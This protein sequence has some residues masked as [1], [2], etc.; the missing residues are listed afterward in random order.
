[1]LF[2]SHKGK[3]NDLSSLAHRSVSSATIGSKH[4]P[5]QPLRRRLEAL[6]C[7]STV[8]AHNRRW[9]NGA[10]RA[11]GAIQARGRSPIATISRL[12][13]G[14]HARQKGPHPKMGPGLGD[15]GSKIYRTRF[16]SGGCR[17]LPDPVGDQGGLLCPRSTWT[18]VDPV[19]RNRQRH[20]TSKRITYPPKSASYAGAARVS[21]SER[22]LPTHSPAQEHRFRRASLR[23][24]SQAS[25]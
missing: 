6:F 9:A 22:I 11:S 18:R 14:T 19:G 23:N 8:A 5:G 24:R 21:E 16:I 12:A 4:V 10:R 3:T 1:M 20:A 15:E 17:H 25:L 2:V 7:I 13:D